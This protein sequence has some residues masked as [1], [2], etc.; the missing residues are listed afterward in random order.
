MISITPQGLVY[1]CKT[2]LEKD[3]KNQ[4]TFTNATNQL[5][6][7]NSK[8]FKSAEDFTYI[9]KDNVI[10][11][12]FPIDE[13]INCNY[14]FYKNTGF[15]SKYYFCFITNM[16]YVNENA[17]RITFETDVWQ[18]FMFDI[19]KKPCFVER[20]HV[21][22]DTI[23]LHTVPENL[24][25]GDFIIN[26]TVDYRLNSIGN[27]MYIVIGLSNLVENFPTPSSSNYNGIYSGLTYYV[28]ETPT[29]ATQFI[30]ALMEAW[31]YDAS[32]SIYCLFIVPRQLFNNITISWQQGTIGD[33]TLDFGLIP[34]S[35][36]ANTLT[37]NLTFSINDNIDGYIPKNN[38]LFTG[39]FNYIQ[40]TN[41][42]GNTAIYKYE[43]FINNTPKF[44]VQGSL[45]VGCSI[46]MDPLNYKVGDPDFL[47]E[48]RTI[49]NYGLMCGKFPT[50]SWN[51][52][53]Y[54]NWLT[55]NAVNTVS[56]ALGGLVKSGIGVATS[57]PYLAASGI[58]DS[59][60]T[61]VEATTSHDT[62]PNQAQGNVN[63]GDVIAS[64]NNMGFYFYKMCMRKEYAKICDDYF[65]MFG[66]KVNTL[67]IPNI[68]GRTNWNYVKTIGCNFEGD[69]PQIYLDKIKEIF[70]TGITLWH[71]ANTML[72][73]SQSNTIVS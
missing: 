44:K 64:S 59:V 21:N 32:Q 18:T 34:S 4:L 63:G 40:A 7:F 19:V 10:T 50:C 48:N 41:N 14:L 73:Y 24:E 38:K 37:D 33:N 56:E 23:G 11:V 13:I 49:K 1:L 47:I 45:T 72:D 9:K 69:I 15:T 22:D 66:Y 53:A 54:T 71:N 58:I 26:K 27:G 8:I 51:C 28:L 70:N 46:R 5:T 31:E 61:V 43:D 68:T 52:D 2:P 60:S 12:N 3:Y 57:N 30:K 35:E 62:I 25:T 29:K 67:K 17:T 55:T 16:E 20:E 42:C 6:Y 36:S 65:S 39:Q